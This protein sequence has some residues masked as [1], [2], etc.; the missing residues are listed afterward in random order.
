MKLRFYDFILDTDRQTLF[1]HNVEIEITKINYEVLLFFVE[2]QKQVITKDQLIDSVWQ[3]KMVTENSIDQSLSKIRKS[4]A[5]FDE[6]IIIKTVF[7]K[8]LEFVAPI[9]EIEN[10][11]INE[12]PK[13]ARAKWIP[14]LTIGCLMLL[15]AWYYRSYILTETK[16]NNQPPILLLSNESN[17]DW[18][19]QSSR[20]LFNQLF[21]NSQYN[22]LIENDKKPAQLSQTEYINNY[23]RINPN[24]EVVLTEL[25]QVN[26]E[27]ILT[28][29][30][31]KKEGSLTETFYHSELPSLL[32]QANQW[33]VS[34]S[35]LRDRNSEIEFLLPQSSH[36]LELY[37]R[38]L[39]S[40]NKGEFEQALNYTELA[41]DQEPSFILAQLQLADIQSR[42]GN[43]QQAIETLDSLKNML[44]YPQ[45]ELSAETLRGDILD[46]SGEYLQAIAI[47]QNLIEQH[48][49]Q[50]PKKLLPVKYNLSYSLTSLLMYDEALQQLDDISI[51]L[52]DDSDPN[53]MADVLQK[54]GSILLQIGRTAEARELANQAFKYYNDLSDLMGSAKV[55]ILLARIANHESDYD[56]AA[57]FLKQSISTFRHA[58]YPI[59]VGASLNE[60]IYTLMV[61]GQFNEA[62][63][64]MLEMKQIAL[65]IN[66]F[67]M[68]MAAKQFEIEISRT[69]KQWVQAEAGLDDYLKLSTD[70]N[71]TRGIFK[72]QLF[73]LDLALDQE[74]AD[75][76]QDYINQI[77]TH[78]DNSGEKRLQP[79][80][81]Y[82]QARVYLL[83]GK[84]QDGLELLS[85][86]KALALT[87]DDMETI[88][89]INNELLRYYIKSGDYEA[90]Q[91][92]ID[93]V[94]KNENKP[95]AY[96]Y[97]LLKSK[98]H[99]GLGQNRLALNLAESCKSQ[100][101]EFWQAADEQYLKSLSS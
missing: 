18:L 100:A 34:N 96:P 2:H 48:Q 65:D 71:F 78:I 32:V 99:H 82:Q 64:H 89:Q 47:Y 43:N 88:H 46:T 21:S 60:L 40:L 1:H 66:Y 55:N 3:D 14:L 93:K 74:Q 36:V 69:R 97:L 56:Q 26:G 6:R 44:Q 16:A 24:L 42:K 68:L 87:T 23:W 54:K 38:G 29:K 53:F 10:E 58:D 5:Q 84:D 22:Y 25:T 51:A 35:S 80:L 28:V 67:A 61:N 12:S 79:R 30:V 17:V 62:W 63:N 92:L 83:Q 98:I 39:E 15:S 72:H 9:E 11:V 85:S 75:R 76:A 41:K 57:Y 27:F 19:N 50:N 59:G 37:M 73:G 81:N 8:G 101:N 31:S 77:Q 20:Q 52:D 4:L 90:A 95:L 49:F 70:E 86:S 94:D 7:G 13:K 45:I 91:K 33:L